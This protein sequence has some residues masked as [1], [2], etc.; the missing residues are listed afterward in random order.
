MF[1]KL[2]LFPSLG[3]GRERPTLWVPKK[4]WLRL[5]LSKGP[6]NVVVFFFCELKTET[7]SFHNVAF[8]SI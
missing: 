8:S 6:Y 5:V 4:E 7:S 3:E 2:K 1:R